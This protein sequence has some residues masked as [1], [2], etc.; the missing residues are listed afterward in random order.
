M[1][2][3]KN[4]PSYSMLKYSL[5][6]FKKVPLTLFVVKCVVWGDWEKL[7]WVL[8]YVGHDYVVPHWVLEVIWGRGKKCP[9][10]VAE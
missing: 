7:Y 8:G 2:K 10:W 5:K 1:Y 3:N 6:F 9:L 4:H